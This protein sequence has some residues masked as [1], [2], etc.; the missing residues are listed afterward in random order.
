[1]DYIFLSSS[2]YQIE[3]TRR[4]V[5]ERLQKN[6]GSRI[7]AFFPSRGD[8]VKQNKF[9]INNIIAIGYRS[10]FDLF[11][12]IFRLIREDKKKLKTLISYSP[13]MNI[14]GFIFSHFFNKH[15]CVISGFGRFNHKYLKPFYFIL[16][17]LS[18]DKNLS[19]ITMN[20]FDLAYI[21]SKK[22]KSIRQYHIESE[23]LIIDRKIISKVVEPRKIKIIFLSR[24]IVSK[25]LDTFLDLV[26]YS[27]S[28]SPSIEFTIIGNGS[29]S[30]IKKI[31]N[32]SKKLPNLNF[33][34][35]LDEKEKVR[36]LIEASHI[37]CLTRYSEGA[38]M[39]LLEGQIYGCIP[40]VYEN[41]ISSECT[42]PVFLKFLIN[43]KSTIEEIHNT[44]ISSYMEWSCS[45]YKKAF[46]YLKDNHDRLLISDKIA[47]IISI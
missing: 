26:N 25:G 43:D 28:V 1:M 5:V 6:K 33:F 2:Q 14:F 40:L 32:L 20:L 46:S 15:I 4:L 16:M 9:S 21:K 42:A 10:Y 45:N 23:G 31:S 8:Y 47:S 30:V 29:D 27:K 38:P 24:L 11:I 37:F 7:Y 12:K 17:Y 35:K 19:I 34:T 39:N 36:I 13:I 18:C 44:I 3:N 22:L 41:S